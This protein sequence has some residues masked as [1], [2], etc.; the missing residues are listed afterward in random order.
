MS[1]Y[2][3]AQEK[4]KVKKNGAC[5]FEN[6]WYIIEERYSSGKRIKESFL[7]CFYKKSAD[8]L[9]MAATFKIL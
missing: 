9:L 4:G 3:V 1:K 6:L 7:F 8:L 5:Y 2:R